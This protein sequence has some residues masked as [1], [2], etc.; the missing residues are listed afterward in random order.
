MVRYITALLGFNNA[1]R[2][3]AAVAAGTGF[4]TFCFATPNPDH[5]HPRPQSYRALRTWIDTAAFKNNAFCWYMASIAFLF[6]GFYPVFFNL[7]EVGLNLDHI[8]VRRHTLTHLLHQWAATRN[9]GYRDGMGAAAGQG[10]PSP[11][12]HE[13]PIQTFWLLSIMNGSSTCGRI[14][15]ASFSDRY[16]PELLPFPLPNP[17][18]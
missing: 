10:P 4:F 11:A 9:F 1:V 5:E 3:V 2:C 14:F 13:D 12:G 17:H 15:M 8:Y 16:F 18:S 6:F 7:E